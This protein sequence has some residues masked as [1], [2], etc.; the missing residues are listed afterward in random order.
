MTVIC[1]NSDW[2]PYPETYPKMWDLIEVIN[3]H[4]KDE[5]PMFEFKEYPKIG[6]DIFHFMEIKGADMSGMIVTYDENGVAHD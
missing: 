2:E 4:N 3:F 6:W 1:I 5:E